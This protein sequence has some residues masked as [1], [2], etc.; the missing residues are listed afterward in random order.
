LERIR[1]LAWEVLQLHGLRSLQNI[2][3]LIVH[4]PIALL[5]V[6]VLFYFCAWIL[7]LES[8]AT[9]GLW[10]LG[11]GTLGAG[12]AVYTGLIA[13]EGVMLAPSVREHIL[14]FHERLMLTVLG[15]STV[16][17]GWA[18]LARPM[19]RRGRIVFVLGL[20]VM[21][22]LLV[23]G[24]DFGGWMVYGYNAGGS[25]PQPIEFSP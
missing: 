25:L 16:L 5:S 19:P 13:G 9:T 12:A 7:R 4:Y 23:K 2:H 21:A 20:L 8:L 6:A 18:L 24:T 15:V 10:M 11:L 1:A 17:A 14:V 3:P 22:A